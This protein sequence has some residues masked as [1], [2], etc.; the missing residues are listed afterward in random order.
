MYHIN[1]YVIAFE[2]E[3]EAITYCSTNRKQSKDLLYY[4]EPVTIG[5]YKIDPKMVK[6][7]KKQVRIVF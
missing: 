6:K 5:K 4:Y 1:P 2:T 3:D 7:A